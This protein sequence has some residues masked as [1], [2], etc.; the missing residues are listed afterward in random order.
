MSI[1]GSCLC[2]TI[3][4][5]LTGDPLFRSLCHCINCQKST[6]SSFLAHSV[7]KEESVEILTG[8]DNLQSYDDKATD[9]GNYLRRRFCR[10]CGSLV[11]GVPEAHPGVVVVALG[12]MDDL[13]PGEWVPVR[14]TF[15]RRRMDWLPALEGTITLQGMK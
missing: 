15:C 1:S 13:Q 3:T 12:T 14:E 4:Y 10:T 7:Y 5:R 11:F 2:G 9:T 8:E 6:G